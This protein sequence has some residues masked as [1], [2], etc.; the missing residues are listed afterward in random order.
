[1]S[2]RVLILTMLLLLGG[3]AFGS[4][5]P[6]R[7]SRITGLEGGDTTLSR[8]VLAGLLS[9]TNNDAD[10]VRSSS[11]DVG[12]ELD[13]LGDNVS[14]FVTLETAALA[15][16]LY[17]LDCTALRDRGTWP[18][19][20]TH[21]QRLHDDIGNELQRLGGPVLGVAAIPPAWMAPRATLPTNEPTPK[22]RAQSRYTA[23]AALL[24]VSGA[25]FAVAA[26][27][28]AFV[29]NDKDCGVLG[30]EFG[31]NIM[32]GPLAIGWSAATAS[33]ITGSV[34]IASG[35]KWSERGRIVPSVAFS[36]RGVTTSMQLQF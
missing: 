32:A 12:L 11:P 26:G 14:G 34:L 36:P 35:R 20:E 9:A 6:V 4:D 33:L 31:R 25:L 2:K 13:R 22:Q 15:T 7:P 27:G 21:Y 16:R 10:R 18:N 3:R 1:M 24:A 17:H 29:M 8:Q 23:G 28:T 30:C 19:P 5:C